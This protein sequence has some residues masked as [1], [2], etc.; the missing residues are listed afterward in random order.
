[1]KYIQVFNNATGASSSTSILL[2]RKNPSNENFDEAN[3]AGVLQVSGN[4]VFVH[5]INASGTTSAYVEWSVDNSNWVKGVTFTRKTYG[6]TVGG[7]GT[8]S[9]GDGTLSANTTSAATVDIG[10]QDEIGSG[11]IASTDKWGQSFE[12]KG[13]YI[14]ITKT[15][16]GSIDAWIGVL[17]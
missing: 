10:I 15:A 3:L 2:T 4:E 5:V 16:G 12:I 7:G 14:R 8:L 9:N 13:P 17:E 11:S 6:N 1:M